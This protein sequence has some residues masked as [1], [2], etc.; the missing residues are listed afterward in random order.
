M[1]IVPNVAKIVLTICL[2][3]FIVHVI[4]S[5]KHKKLSVRNS[6]IWLAM[7]IAAVVCIWI[8]PL[9][10]VFI[11]LI[12]I[13]TVS[14]LLFF[15]GFIFMI[16]VTFDLAKTIS[17]QNKKIINLTQDLAILKHEVEN[18]SKK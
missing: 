9:L 7:G 11:D 15:L 2:L 10:E 17:I 6:L 8:I 18:D 3:I 13:E 16:F 12:G 4:N 1:I 5:V 14:N